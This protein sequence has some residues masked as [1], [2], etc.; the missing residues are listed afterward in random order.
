MLNS[1]KRK[2]K[3]KILVAEDDPTMRKLLELQLV[4]KGYEVVSVEDG[5]QALL[6]VQQDHFDLVISDIIMPFISGLELLNSLRKANKNI[7]VI[8]CSSLHSE[9]AINK[10]FEIGA[11]GFISK[12]YNPDE[13]LTKVKH[14]LQEEIEKRISE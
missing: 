7:A 12:P 1:F 4:G 10:A 11:N 6:Y 9:N 8:I 3:K 14:V 2:A 5:R 13:M